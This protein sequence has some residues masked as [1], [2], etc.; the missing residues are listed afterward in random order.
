[1]APP[2][3]GE[4]ES[5]S[6]SLD[7]DDV[8]DGG[9]QAWLVVFGSWCCNFVVSGWLNG[10]GVFQDYYS[11]ELFPHLPTSTIALLSSLVSLIIFAGVSLSLAH[12]ILHPSNHPTRHNFIFW[13]SEKFPKFAKGA[14]LR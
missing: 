11:T 10:M 9:W 6:D 8:P 5:D 14:D 12:D 3:I 2:S 4:L 1:M 13:T 7:Y